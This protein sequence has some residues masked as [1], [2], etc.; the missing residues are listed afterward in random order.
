MWVELHNNTDLAF[1]KFCCFFL[2]SERYLR[3]LICV[4]I[5]HIVQSDSPS[6]FIGLW[7][8]S[9]KVMRRWH[10][11]SSCFL[12]SKSAP[13]WEP[14]EEWWKLILPLHRLLP[15]TPANHRINTVEVKVSHQ[16][17]CW[18]LVTLYK[19]SSMTESLKLSL[20]IMS[21]HRAKR[22]E[23]DKLQLFSW[24]NRP[25]LNTSDMHFKECRAA[26]QDIHIVRYKLL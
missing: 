19:P 8:Y 9:R 26:R 17:H 2:L 13:S 16:T 3:S 15:L 12:R 24:P 22:I 11:A 20:M 18:R 23:P 5:V 21:G 10:F 14:G 1:S 6:Y 25:T 4:C 7:K